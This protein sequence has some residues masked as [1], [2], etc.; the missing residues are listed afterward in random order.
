DEAVEEDTE[1]RRAKARVLASQNQKQF[2][3]RAIEL[4]EGLARSESLLPDDRYVLS[5]LYEAEG[6]ERKARDELGKL[7][8]EPRN[9]Q[10]LARYALRL[11]TQRQ[12]PTD[13]DEAEKKIG[14]LEE[15]ERQREVGPNGFASVELR[16]R[17]E[18]ARGRPDE[19]A[20]RLRRHV[21]RAGAKPEEVLLL[22]TALARQKKYQEAFALC[23]K[24]WEQGK[25]RP[26]MLG[27]VCM[28]MLRVRG[29]SD[30]QVARFEK[31]LRAAVDKDPDSAVL[32]MHLSALCDL[33]GR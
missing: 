5:L 18:E 17:V 9:R 7:I 19:A 3:T 29:P 26:E 32:R 20:K 30:G 22:L 6:Q 33:R 21:N 11:I 8:R 23:E 10:H 13:L 4:L 31:H 24:T 14:W 1:A 27:G 2:R 28:E 25:V 15:L 12:L 16:A